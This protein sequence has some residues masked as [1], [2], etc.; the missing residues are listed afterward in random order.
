MSHFSP[1]QLHYRQVTP[2]TEDESDI[3]RAWDKA[4]R[5]FF[6]STVENSP[7]ALPTP[8]P[9]G[10]VSPFINLTLK[11]SSASSL[12]NLRVSLPIFSPLAF[13]GEGIAPFQYSLKP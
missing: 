1:S 10:T 7:A 13:P 2:I 3:D 12:N 11:S 9:V 6:F 4:G 5:R 8:P